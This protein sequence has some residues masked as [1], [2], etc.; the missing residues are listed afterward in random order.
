MANSSW[1]GALD[2]AGRSVN[3]AL[4]SRLKSRSAE[5]FKTLAP[6][7]KP[8]KQVKISSD[9]YAK[10]E[11]DPK[12]EVTTLG[13]NDTD[14][15][16]P[17][18]GGEFKALPEEAVTAITGA[19][20]SGVV[21]AADYVPLDSLP[22]ELALT[23]YTVVPDD[24]VVGA[25]RDVNTVW[26]GLRASGLAYITTITMKAGSRDSILAIYADD[27][28]MHAVTLP[29]AAEVQPTPT[30]E[31]TA[32]EAE[33]DPVKAFIEAK[34][35]V[36]AFDHGEYESTYR[37]TREDAIAKALAGVEIPK[38][39]AAPKAEAGPS[40]M[41]SLADAADTA[42]SKPKKKPAAKKPPAKK[43][44]VKA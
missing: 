42:T 35:E 36:E 37:K 7:G 5:S 26:N 17:I 21:E 31:F 38:P 4:Y 9:E 16:V 33:A 28:G 12:A 23:S 25:E 34:Y 15:G 1:R 24:K 44:K 30:H 3:V 29:F 27:D 40:L 6:D 14:K 32:D 18:G 20:K 19:A 2:L 39:K 41:E 10:L 22:L 11:A 13:T 43:A 8:I